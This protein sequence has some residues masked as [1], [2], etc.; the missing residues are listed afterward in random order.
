MKNGSY[1]E[2]RC[3]VLETF[4][5]NLL[6]EQYTIGQAAGRGLVE[7]RSEAQ[8]G[9]QDA[10]V[11]LSVLLSRIARHEP[12][13]LARF[14][15]QV[16]ALRAIGKKSACWRGLAETEKKRLQEDLRFVLEKAGPTSGSGN[17]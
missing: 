7:F 2:L 6:A 12:K 9:G 1:F 10:L 11:V 5:E 4:Y 14:A 3:A 16:E 13:T 15:P 17:G 8:G